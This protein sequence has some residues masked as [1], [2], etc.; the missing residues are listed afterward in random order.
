[1]LHRSIS[2]SPVEPCG[3]CQ[4]PGAEA[5]FNVK[6]ALL[7]AKSHPDTVLPPIWTPTTTPLAPSWTEI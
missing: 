2:L 4:E 3:E 7:G 1:M 5:K 6:G